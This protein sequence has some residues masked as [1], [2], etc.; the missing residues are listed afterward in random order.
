MGSGA[1]AALPERWFAE[2]KQK[3]LKS[4]VH[5]S[6]RALERNIRAW[7]AGLAGLN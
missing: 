6:V 2:L 7:L 4:G 1:G 3:E 5:H